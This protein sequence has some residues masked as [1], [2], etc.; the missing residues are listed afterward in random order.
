MPPPAELRRGLQDPAP[1]RT[2]GE[3]PAFG[4]VGQSLAV[5][6]PE[7]AAVRKPLL[8]GK[9]FPCPGWPRG[10]EGG[11]GLGPE[12]WKKA[13]KSTRAEQHRPSQGILDDDQGVAVQA[14]V[15]NGGMR[16]GFIH[17]EALLGCNGD[18]CEGGQ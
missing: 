17:R 6:L 7:P 4:R 1:S 8:T 12:G 3:G 18:F 16:V 10:G 13:G 9:C 5:S 11:E 15:T 2:S 14:T